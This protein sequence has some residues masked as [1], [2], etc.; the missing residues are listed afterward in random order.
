MIERWM[1]RFPSRGKASPKNEH[2]LVLTPF[3]LKFRFPSRGKAYPKPSKRRRNKP[4]LTVSIPFDRESVSKGN[5]LATS[6]TETA[7][8][9]FPSNGKA[10][11]KSQEQQTACEQVPVSIPFQRESV[12]KVQPSDNDEIR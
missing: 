9:Q 5:S 11:P 3:M 7:E 8:F 2:L 4:H 10:Y 1:F 12:S 6:I